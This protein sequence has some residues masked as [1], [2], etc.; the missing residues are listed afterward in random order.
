M[1]DDRLYDITEVCRL[2][3]T[4]SR[5][6]RFYEKNGIIQSTTVGLSNRRQYTE[7]QLSQIKNVIV[8]RALGLSV[9]TISALQ[10]NDLELKNTIILKRAELYA[11]I[12]KRIREIDLLNEALAQMA[13]GKNILE[14]ESLSEAHENIPAQQIA[15]ECT[16]EIID[17][18]TDKLYNHFSDKLIAYMPQ[19]VFDT[20]REDA[21]KPLG[22][23]IQ[24]EKT[25]AVDKHKICKYLKYSNLGLKITYI[26]NNLKIDGLWLNYYDTKK[27]YINEN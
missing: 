24:T 17:G 19:K 25:V 23:F 6:L 22:A 10:K 1:N 8:L 20:I 7:K 9:K 12:E 21:L 18:H 27:E 16:M 11:S 26:I 13:D 3:G 5:T 2:L 4:T 15:D 14:T